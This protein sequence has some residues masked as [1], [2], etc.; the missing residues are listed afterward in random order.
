MSILFHLIQQFLLSDFHRVFLLEDLSKEQ[1]GALI[2]SSDDKAMKLVEDAASIFINGD[3]YLC[4]F[5]FKV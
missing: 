3:K 4:V 5:Y 2:D 1:F